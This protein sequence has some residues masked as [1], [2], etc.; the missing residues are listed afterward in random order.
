MR[1]HRPTHI[2]VSTRA[3]S[4]RG[5]V[6]APHESSVAAGLEALE[7]GGNA[8]DA[9]VAAA[10]VAGVVEPTET[11]LAGSGFGLYHESGA[12]PWSI[13]FGPKAPLSASSTMFDIDPAAEGSAVLGLTPVVGNANLDGPL[14]SGVPRTLLGLLTAQERFGRLSRAKVCEPAIR[15]AHDGF[16]ADTWFITN[17]LSDIA[18]LRADDQAR[19]V[20]LDADGLPVGAQT[21]AAQGLSFQARPHV[22]QPALGATLEE[23]SASG[24]SSLIDG[25]IAGR[26]A[27]SS[28][29]LGGLLSRADL[30]SAAPTT[31]PAQSLRYR[32][33]DVAVPAAPGGGV[34]QLQ[35]LALWQALH[36]EPRSSHADPVATRRLAL[37]MR[38]AFADRYQWLGDPA[39]VPVP[40]S[41]LLDP[42]YADEIADL[43]RGDADVP[44]WTHGQPWVTYASKAVHDPWLHVPDHG[45]RP[46]WR[47]DTASRPSSGT[48]HISVA[49]ADGNIASVTHTAANHFG[50]GVACP[51][52]GLLFDSAMAWFN[53]APGAANSISPSGR[54]LANMAPA[55]VIKD[56]TAKAALGAS[57]GRRIIGAVAQ[58]V[59]DLV[60]GGFPIEEVLALPRID[61]SGRNLLVHEGLSGHVEAVAD[62][63]PVVIPH[64]NE[65][66]TM[67]F[68]RPNLAGYDA[69][70]IPTS[71]VN[72]LH[73][74]D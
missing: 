48:T 69:A 12:Q 25:V 54:A 62:L 21:A 14:A 50:N 23:A 63:D 45:D 56:G 24:P 7:S 31:S 19:S 36:P 65:P 61:A 34:T 8:M 41:G 58:I 20:F 47:P 29:E 68:S 9:A 66:F 72:T 17:A 2:P 3:D 74:N 73:Y 60:D 55:L 28:T 13:D 44:G 1:S 5:T 10:L 35:I 57:G 71:A 40:T 64:S 33:V 15:A 11:T 18:R 53:A 32:D 42:A 37:A 52:T 30:R 22:R 51:R 39:V 26:L 70:G 16:P 59:I 49:D 43:I 4:E 27:E 46:V 6:T 67:D 38:H